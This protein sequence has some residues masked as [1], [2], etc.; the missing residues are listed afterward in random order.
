MK[1]KIILFLIAFLITIN[2]SLKAKDNT[3]AHIIGHVVNKAEHLPYANVYI[4]GTTIG[5]STDE[6]GHYQLLNLPIGN[7]TIV[8]QMIGYKSKEIKVQTKQGK[9]NEIK[10]EL[11]EDLLG[12]E[13][14]VITGDRNKVN[15]SK[16]PVIVSAIPPKLLNSTQSISVSEGLNYC[17]GLRVENNCQNCGF[18]Q[19]RINGLEGPYSQILINSRPVFSGLAGVYG[20]ELIPTNMIKRIEVVRGGGSALYGSNAIAGTVNIILKNPI[21]NS[22]EFGYNLNIIG[23]K[24]PVI[25]HNITANASIVSSDNQSGMTMYAFNRNRKH[26]DANN[27]GF[28]EL[29]SIKNTTFGIKVFHRI[30]SKNKLSADFFVINETRRGG[31]KFESPFHETDITEAVKHNIYSATLNFD[32]FFRNTDLFSTYISFQKVDRDSYYG[33][34]KSLNSYGKTNS[35]NYVFGSTYKASFNHSNLIIGLETQ[36]EW[37]ED[38]K[39]AYT[40]FHNP[41][42]DDNDN[43]TYLHYDKG[44]ISDQKLNISGGFAQYGYQFLK[45]KISAGLRF[46]HYQIKEK[47]HSNNTSGNVLSP[48]INFLYDLVKNIQLRVGYSKGYRA[49]Q[50]FD[51]DLHI[52]SSETRKIIHKN[53]PNLKQETSHSFIGSIDYHNSNSKGNFEFLLEFFYTILNNPFANT[54][55]T[56][57]NNGVVVY[58]RINAQGGAKVKGMNA[59]LTYIP[60]STF[61][62]KAGFTIQSSKYDN[63]IEFNEKRFLRSP[64]NYGFMNILFIPN[65][66]W[67]FSTTVTYTGKMLIPYYGPQSPNGELRESNLF[68]DLGFKIDKKFKIGSTKLN[69]YIGTKNLF[70]SYQNDFDKGGDRDPAYIYGPSLPRSFY[71]G[72]KISK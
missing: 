69:I 68:F 17:P 31:N 53:D 2:L 1:K 33:A 16:S 51:E 24:N 37:L 15:R 64:D 45:L 35:F 41:I 67:E 29:S 61:N 22:Y 21:N 44:V 7:L 4:K 43:V 66:S 36:G 49:P 52:A 9:T 72:I 65:H 39:L 23:A 12:L 19:L 11:E 28:S 34:N 32:R 46:D 50:I 27:D 38:T 5:V 30:D 70:N 62:L 71:F 55:G 57:D 25:D 18:T 14:V 20:L 6:T 63:A 26:F 3:D 58:T 13:E 40:D 56:P 59:E 47:V 10:F 60:S 48:R 42:V 8:A 54:Y